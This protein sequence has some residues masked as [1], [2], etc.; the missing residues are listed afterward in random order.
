M[1]SSTPITVRTV[2]SGLVVVGIVVLLI[3]LLQAYS[4]YRILSSWTP[5]SA[6]FV[7]ANVSNQKINIPIESTRVDRYLV[8]WTLRYK[9]GGIKREAIIDPGTHGNYGQMIAWTQRFY[10]G[11]QVS[12]RYN[13]AN[14]EEISAAGYDWATFSHAAWVAAWG[15]CIILLGL[16]L[17]RETSHRSSPPG[18]RRHAAK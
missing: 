18:R 2:G 17:P 11:E 16:V 5:V 13:P 8:T 7:R 10:P 6:Q 14:L 9:V 3:G 1:A 15:I 12:I 4:Q